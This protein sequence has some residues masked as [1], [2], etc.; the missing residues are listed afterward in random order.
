MVF[1]LWK[2]LPTS[3]K[4]RRTSG[5]LLAPPSL[6]EA[7]IETAALNFYIISSPP[8]SSCQKEVWLVWAE[9]KNTSCWSV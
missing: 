6:S 3:T 5:H 4:R 1:T 2:L 8:R 9:L 7:L